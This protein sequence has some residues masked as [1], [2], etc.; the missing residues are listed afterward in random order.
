MRQ[1]SERVYSLLSLAMKAGAVASGQVAALQTIAGGK[2][3]LA[4]IAADAS[5]NTKK[6]VKNNCAYYRVPC[7]V[8]GEKDKLGHCIGKEE[9]SLLAVTN[10]S[11]A[12]A[13]ERA[14]REEDS[15]W[16]K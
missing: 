6:K 9:R 16:R 12:G 7:I 14:Y 8:F 2:A 5:D 13:V 1:K 11:L 15:Q 4:V 10:E 3:C